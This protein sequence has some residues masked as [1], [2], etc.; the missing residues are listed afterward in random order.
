[1]SIDAGKIMIRSYGGKHLSGTKGKV[2]H[3]VCIPILVL[4]VRS[5]ATFKAF[6]CKKPQHMVI[7]FIRL[8]LLRLKEISIKQGNSDGNLILVFFQM[9]ILS[10][11]VLIFLGLSLAISL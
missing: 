4:R 9:R 11:I 7:F 5:Q 8:N 3:N 10:C 1:M 6:P 2:L